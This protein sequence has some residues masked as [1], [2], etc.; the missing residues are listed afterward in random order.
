MRGCIS[1]GYISTDW[2]SLKWP[3][4]TV[5]RVSNFMV[6]YEGGRSLT[7]DT[8]DRQLAW[9]VK[10]NRWAIVLTS[11]SVTKINRRDHGVATARCSTVKLGQRRSGVTVWEVDA[12]TTQQCLRSRDDR[13][14]R[15][16]PV[17][18]MLEDSGD[19]PPTTR[20]ETLKAVTVVFHSDAQPVIQ[21]PGSGNHTLYVVRSIKRT[22]GL[23]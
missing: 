3:D 15:Q 17:I 20:L 2:A 6:A 5:Y 16:T 21:P 9:C 18:A 13:Q 23:T 4:A 22:V 11:A 8:T 14:R 19:R 7:R 12:W 1:H 10:I